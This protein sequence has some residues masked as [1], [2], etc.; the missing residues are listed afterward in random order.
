VAETIG[1]TEQ[2]SADLLLIRPCE[3]S[4]FLVLPLWQHSCLFVRWLLQCV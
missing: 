2:L 3:L 4:L 1:N